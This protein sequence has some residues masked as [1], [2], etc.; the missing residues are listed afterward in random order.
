M[1]NQKLVT[2]LTHWF[3]VPFADKFLDWAIQYTMI[4]PRRK[5]TVRL[6][7]QRMVPGRT[8]LSSPTILFTL[9]S[10]YLSH[11]FSMLVLEHAIDILVDTVGGPQGEMAND[12]VAAYDPVF[13]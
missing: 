3:I 1:K 9:R 6:A 10:S 12:A 7:T 13:W 2:Y 11:P 4:S 8:R 5:D